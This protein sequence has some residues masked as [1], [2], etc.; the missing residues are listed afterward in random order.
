MNIL[1]NEIAPD[2][3]TSKALNDENVKI[4]SNEG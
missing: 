4:Q 1:L 2:K 3:Y